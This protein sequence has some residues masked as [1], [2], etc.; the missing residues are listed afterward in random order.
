MSEKWKNCSKLQNWS[1]RS[2]D[3]CHSQHMILCVCVHDIIMKLR[4][5]LN[6]CPHEYAVTSNQSKVV[7]SQLA[8]AISLIHLYN[9][10]YIAA[11]MYGFST[12]LHVQ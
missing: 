5:D 6:A 3:H 8:L 7:S 11:T 9:Y 4:I 1:Y 2:T 10:S 12:W